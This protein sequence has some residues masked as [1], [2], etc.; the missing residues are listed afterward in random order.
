MRESNSHQR[1]WRPLSYHLTNPL[2]FINYYLMK[3]TCNTRHFTRILYCTF[4]TSYR[5]PIRKTPDHA[6]S[7][8]SP[9]PVSDSQLRMLPFL[10]PCPIHPVFPGGSYLP[11]QGISRLEGGF[12][13]RC[14][15]RLSRPDLATLPCHWLTAGAPEVRPSRSSRTG[16]SSSQISRAR[17]G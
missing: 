8:S 10:H 14:L 5:I 7:W 12:T 17:A 2:Y 1:F 15:Q 3:M 11:S 6:F 16:D 13:L 9:R 4:K